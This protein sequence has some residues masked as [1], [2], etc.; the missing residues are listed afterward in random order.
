MTPASWTWALVFARCLGFVSRAPGFSHP[1]VPPVARA[2]IAFTLALGLFP[3]LAAK[4]QPLV[5]AALLG[6][7]FLG[8]AI[9]FAA[10]ILYDGAAAGGAMLDDYVGIHMQNPQ[11]QTGTGQGFAQLWGL[12]FLAAFFVLDGYQ[13]VLL[14]L[15]DSL[16]TI[17]PG[18]AFAVAG[19]R[20]FA[21]SVPLLIMRAATLVAGPAL[22]LGLVANV[23]LG[24]ISRI[25]P[26][27][28]NFTLTF[29][30]VFTVV[31]LA[32]LVTV[33]SV[34]D[35]GGHPWLPAPLFRR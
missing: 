30:V 35:A 15:A 19:L 4:S 33:R 18:D 34:L 17:P 31:L 14:A 11:A 24:A 13:F 26:R 22:A 9:G 2:G 20:E 5:I 6:E 27:F 28:T 7:L 3:A 29:P 12:G 32:T 25:I 1:S 21:L 23:A 16:R 8:A 10:S